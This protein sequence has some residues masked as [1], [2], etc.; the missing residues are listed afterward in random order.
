MSRPPQG[1][2]PAQLVAAAPG[3]ADWLVFQRME[4]A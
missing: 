1:W 2:E 3:A 4:P